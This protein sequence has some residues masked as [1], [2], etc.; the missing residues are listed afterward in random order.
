[1]L[2][3]GFGVPF[4]PSY[5][6][7]TILRFFLGFGAAGTMVIS[8]VII[9]ETVG[10]D[11]R[12]SLGCL[13]QIPFVVG[14]M[15]VPLFAYYFRTWDKYC[16]AMVVPQVIYIGYFFILN[17]SPRWLVSVGRVEEATKIVKKAAAM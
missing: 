15:S 3:F 7:F 10:P 4:S 1:M 13:Y 12:E 5:T 8:F 9:M 6:I 17:E 14:H 11:Y 2:A 16:L